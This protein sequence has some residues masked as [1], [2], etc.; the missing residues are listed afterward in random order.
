MCFASVQVSFSPDGTMVVAG[1]FDG[2][3]IVW[4]VGSGEVVSTLS[5]HHTCPVNSVCWTNFGVAS[6][7]KEGFGIFWG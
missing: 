1:S 6:C 3:I 5:G 7:D 2:S 4:D